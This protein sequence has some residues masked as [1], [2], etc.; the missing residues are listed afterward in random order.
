MGIARF[1]IGLLPTYSQVGLLAPVL[2]A[3][4]RFAQGLALGG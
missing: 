1:A 2:L 3:V 4:L